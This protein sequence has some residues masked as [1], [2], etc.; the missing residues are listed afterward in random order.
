MSFGIEFDREKFDLDEEKACEKI[1]EYLHMWNCF[2][3]EANMVFFY[4]QI[5]NDEWGISN[6][7]NEDAFYYYCPTC[8]KLSE[9]GHK[10]N[11]WE[12]VTCSNCYQ[13][14]Y[15][16]DFRSEEEY[17]MMFSFELGILER[18]ERGYAFRIFEVGL[19]YSGREKEDYMKL[20]FYPSVNYEET[21]REY[22]EEGNVEYYTVENGEKGLV[23][24]EVDKIYD[25]DVILSDSDLFEDMG[26]NRVADVVW[27]ITGKYDDNVTFIEFLKRCI[28]EKAFRTLKK[29]GFDAILDELPYCRHFYSNSNKISEVLDIDYNALISQYETD[30]VTSEEIKNARTLK[31]YGI[32]LTRENVEIAEKLYD[33][34][35]LIASPLGQMGKLY[36]YLRR[37][38]RKRGSDIIVSDYNDYLG[39]LEKLEYD[40][41]D[42]KNLMPEN[43]SKTHAEL[44]LILSIKQDEKKKEPFYNSAKKYDI[45][46]AEHSGFVI[47]AITDIAELKKEGIALHHCVGGY[48]DRVISGN[49]VIFAIRKTEEKDVPYVTLELSPKD[50]RIVQYRGIENNRNVPM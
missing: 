5:I 14:G 13:C 29:Y 32:Q 18:F 23:F 4:G 1:D 43:L 33:K 47:G 28:P 19:D 42:L 31:E 48:D 38:I 50:M 26:G 30:K 3:E 25:G 17:D 11:D 20:S 37:E 7:Y 2:E 46:N 15:L 21:A 22:W 10:P 9:L 24:E 49:S 6:L 8:G 36:K 16:F 41:N 27:E 12:E 44:S 45:Y 39:Q 35:Y 40:V 34:A